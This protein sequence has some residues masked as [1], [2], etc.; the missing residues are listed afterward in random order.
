MQRT[1]EFCGALFEGASQARFCSNAHRV[2]ASRTRTEIPVEVELA[3]ENS[4]GEENSHREP[5]RVQGRTEEEYVTEMMR[6]S[7]L[8]NTVG[9]DATFAMARARQEAYARWRWRG[10]RDGEVSGL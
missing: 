9:A 4:H 2:A 10:V 8:T 3:Q 6:L 7:P 5:Q 1:C